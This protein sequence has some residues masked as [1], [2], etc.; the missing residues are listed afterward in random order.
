MDSTDLY[1]QILGLNSNWQVREVKLKMQAGKVEIF[2][3]Y[4]KETCPIPFQDEFPFGSD[5]RQIIGDENLFD[6]MISINEEA[7]LKRPHSKD[8]IHQTGRQ[9]ITN[10]HSVNGI[11]E[12]DDLVDQDGLPLARGW[13]IDH[14]YPGSLPVNCLVGGL[15]ARVGN[16]QIGG[17]RIFEQLFKEPRFNH[18]LV[19]EIHVLSPLIRPDTRRENFEHSFQFED[20][21][22]ALEVFARRITTVCR[23]KSASRVREKVS[24]K[25]TKISLEQTQFNQLVSWLELSEPVNE[26]LVI[27][28]KD[29]K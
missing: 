18:W 20:L 9:V 28:V 19:G 10:F 17:S 7:T 27:S 3:E 12:L 26:Q 6:I 5:V 2:G 23:E 1:Q 15:R 22:N 14:D 16:I 21:I 25:N 4:F 24:Y 8:I 11:H 29:S 13:F